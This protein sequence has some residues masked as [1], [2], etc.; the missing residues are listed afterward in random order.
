MGNCMV[1]H[2]NNRIVSLSPVDDDEKLKH[3]DEKKQRKTNTKRETTTVR[4]RVLVT[5]QELREILMQHGNELKLEQI[6]KV[7]V[8]SRRRN[9]DDGCGEGACSWRPTLESIPEDH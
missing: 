2:N 3:F 1:V 7:A 8:K 9:V 5:K 6:V 4:I